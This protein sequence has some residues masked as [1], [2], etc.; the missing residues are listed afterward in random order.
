[1]REA[2]IRLGSE[3]LVES[4]VGRGF[5]VRPLVREEIEEVFPLLWTLEPLALSLSPPFEAAQAAELERIAVELADPEAPARR[6]HELDAA[7]HRRLIGRCPNARLL[8]YVEE[9]RGALVRYET[10]YLQTILGMEQS[11]RDHRAIAAAFA[12]GDREGASELL[13]EHWHRGR[14]ELLAMIPKET[15]A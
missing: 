13:R 10:A 6:R 1:V 15:E 12:G 2:L 14:G 7:W 11:V 3:G 5:R 4:R 9:L 8:R